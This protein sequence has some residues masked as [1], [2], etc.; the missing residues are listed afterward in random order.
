[1][2][3]LQKSLVPSWRVARSVGHDL[4]RNNENV[5][6]IKTQQASFLFQ[7]I[8]RVS[9]HRKKLEEVKSVFLHRSTTTKRRLQRSGGAWELDHPTWRPG[10]RADICSSSRASCLQAQ[11]HTRWPELIPVGGRTAALCTNYSAASMH[12]WFTVTQWNEPTAGGQ[13]PRDVSFSFSADISVSIW[14]W[15]GIDHICSG[16]K[17]VGPLPDFSFTELGFCSRTMIQNTPKSLSL[18]GW[19][20]TK[21]R[22]WRGLVKVP[23]LIGFNCDWI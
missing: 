22:L 1:M 13:H 8:Q 16:L 3:N 14:R 18:T 17:T 11:W 20:K 4:S 2:V 7:D 23:T 5:L 19:R 12:V 9:D 6:Q 10:Q 15:L 21:W